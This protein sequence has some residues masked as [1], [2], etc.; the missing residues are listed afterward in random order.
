MHKNIPEQYKNR[1]LRIRF[2][3]VP[4]L[5]D[6][7]RMNLDNTADNLHW[8]DLNLYRISQHNAVPPCFIV[9]K[10]II[11]ENACNFMRLIDNSYKPIS[12]FFSFKTACMPEVI[13][14]L[15]EHGFG[16]EV[17]SDYELWLALKLGFPP[18][19]IIANG[20]GKEENFIERAVKNNIKLIN[21]DSE[22]EINTV[23]RISCKYNKKREVLVRIGY[24]APSHRKQ[25][26]FTFEELPKIMRKIAR[27]EFLILKGLHFHVGTNIQSLGIYKDCIKKSLMFM[28]KFNAY[29]SGPMT[30]DIGGGFPTFNTRNFNK[31]ELLLMALI[32]YEPKLN[33]KPKISREN[34]IK[35][36]IYFFKKESTRLGIK[37]NNLLLEPGR[38][39]TEN[40]QILL[41]RV[42]DIKRKKNVIYAISDCGKYSNAFWSK[43]EYHELFR[44]NNPSGQERK[45]YCVC[46]KLCSDGDILHKKKTLP[47][48]KIGDLLVVMD[49]G[50]YFS[51]FLNNFSFPAPDIYIHDQEGVHP[52]FWNMLEEYK[53]NKKL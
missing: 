43:Y 39:I 2:L 11:K 50:A 10:K 21:L 29:F 47:K 20:A 18:E 41:T 52:I 4:N 13:N 33:Q 44:V 32:D 49:T 48:L 36:I 24:H 28:K 22:N 17:V 38:V 34:F 45:S 3:S 35:E 5:E 9:S 16:A 46:G 37:K 7:D 12:A 51:S 25:F 23:E 1:N 42:L 53:K 19:K 30:L 15:F 8:A 27:S 26:G 14:I 6:H 40:A 31:L